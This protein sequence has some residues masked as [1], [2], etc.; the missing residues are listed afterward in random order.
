[1]SRPEDYY[2]KDQLGR[3]ID[4]SEE[5]LEADPKRK[6]M[7]IISVKEDFINAISLATAFMM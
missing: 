7:I 6:H 1:M 2:M 4:Y 5:A 3:I